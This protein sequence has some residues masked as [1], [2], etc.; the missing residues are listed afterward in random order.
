M[1]EGPVAYGGETFSPA[2]DKVTFAYDNDGPEVMIIAIPIEHYAKDR[3]NGMALLYGKIREAQA[4]A[5]RRLT[6]LRVKTMSTTGI[7]KPGGNGKL[8]LA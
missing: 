3:E 6:E 2:R 4:I 8:G 5:S 1:S 7:L